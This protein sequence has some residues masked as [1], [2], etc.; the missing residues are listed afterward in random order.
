MIERTLIDT[1]PLVALYSDDDPHHERCKAALGELNP[2]LFTCFPVLTEVA[3]LL[4]KRPDGFQAIIQG[5]KN[6]FF[7]ILP[8]SGED[9]SAI[10][11]LMRRYEDSAIQFADAALAHLA[12]R[13]SIRTILTLDR[14]DFSII[15][16]KRNRALRLLPEMQ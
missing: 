5:F 9:L 6:G 16:L 3:W 8:L 12:E 2:P 1:G 11:E 7:A 13:E 15:R 14:R 4:R 10:A